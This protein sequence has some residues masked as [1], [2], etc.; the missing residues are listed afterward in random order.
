[1]AERIRAWNEVYLPPRAYAEPQ[2]RVLRSPDGTESLADQL[3]LFWNPARRL[4][5]GLVLGERTAADGAKRK[6]V[7]SAVEYLPERVGAEVEQLTGRPFAPAG[8]P[9]LAE[10]AVREPDMSG[11]P[12]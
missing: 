12:S 8:P 11:T 1:M 4:Q 10:E 2:V 3:P 9:L 5:W 6:K 7:L